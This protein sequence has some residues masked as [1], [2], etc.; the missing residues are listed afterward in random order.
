MR[1]RLF[2]INNLFWAVCL[3]AVAA[4]LVNAQKIAVLTPDGDRQAVAYSVK[5]T[6]SL[7]TRFRILDADMSNAAFRSV[8]SDNPYN[9]T[10]ESSKNLGSVL[11]CDYFLLVR[12]GTPRRAAFDRPDY[13]E[14]F[15]VVFVVSSRTGRLLLWKLQNA[16]ADSQEKAESQL[17]ATAEELGR[18]IITE[19][20]G[21]AR[22]E[23]GEASLPPSEEIPAE[24]SPAAINF[25]APVP[26]LRFPPE[27]TRT[28]YLYGIKATVEIQVD[29]DAGG[30][31]L[32]TEVVRWAGYGLDES[33]D[34]AVRKMNWRPAERGGKTLPIR[35]L[36]RYNFKKIEKE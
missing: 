28:A 15:A 34:N 16:E 24:N 6:E 20:P 9:L 1:S 8:G 12:S 30:K 18:T 4:G 19:L 35:F 14:A 5:L 33:V 29:L 23:T 31:I 7:A 21:I 17:L 13:F 11:G 10:L 27:Y 25:R 32:Q 22:A 3:A 26:Y 2:I 36:L